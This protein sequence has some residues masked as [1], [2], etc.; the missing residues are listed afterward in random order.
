MSNSKPVAVSVCP[1][2]AD[3]EALVKEAVSQRKILLIAGNCWVEYIGRAKS[4]LEPGERILIIKED[5][6]LL[7]HRSVGYEPVNWQ[8]PGCIFQTRLDNDVLEIRA[9][10]LKPQESVS[11]YF[12]RIYMVSMLALTDSGEFSMYASEEEMQKAILVEPSLLE[13]NFKPISYEKRVEP[14]FVD[15]YG[16][17]SHGR[18]VV[19]EIKRRTAS[20]EAV[21]QLAK[22]ID[23]IKSKTSRQVRGILVAPDIA[24][25][26]QR[27]LETLKLEFKALSPKKCA[28][29]LK[30]SKTV[31][32]EAFLGEKPSD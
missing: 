18:F 11:V 2:L 23:A 20:K 17:D 9:L 5:G 1:N 16:V 6:S 3:A 21:L 14:G 29:V 7:V 27:V 25:D 12:N 19:V 26:A 15:I 28:E 30:R 13:E 31:K 10:R 4:K 22:Y 24:K 8:P 32:L